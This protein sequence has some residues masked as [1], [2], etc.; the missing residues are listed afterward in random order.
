MLKNCCNELE[1]MVFFQKIK[2]KHEFK[3]IDI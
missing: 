3:D 2:R 1:D